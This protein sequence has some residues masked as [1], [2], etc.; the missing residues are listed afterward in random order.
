MQTKTSLHRLGLQKTKHTK[1]HPAYVRET[2]SEQKP[3][4]EF[5]RPGESSPE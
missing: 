1:Y 4:S 3:G 5:D 2:K